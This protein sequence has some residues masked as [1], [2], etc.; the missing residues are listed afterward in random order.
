[1][2]HLDPLEESQIPLKRALWLLRDTVKKGT[3]GDKSANS[4]I[5]S[6]VK[7]KIESEFQKRRNP[8]FKKK[9]GPKIVSDRIYAIKAIF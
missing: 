1:M 7:K 4:K 2:T 5:K 3:W 6:L 8:R 9:L